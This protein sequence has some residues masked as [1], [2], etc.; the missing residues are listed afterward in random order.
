M[1]KTFS[2]T[3]S[4]LAA[5]A[6]LA[7]APLAARAQSAG[8]FLGIGAGA[9]RVARTNETAARL[10]PSLHLRTGWT[11]NPTVS[12]V[13]EGTLNGIG[14]PNPADP[15]AADS[16][17]NGGAYRNRQLQTGA[18]LLAVQLGSARTLYV[19]PGIGIARHAFTVYRPLPADGYA[20]ETGYEGGP[21][22]GVAVGREIAV[23]P[24]FPLSV[25]A[26]ALYSRGEDSTSPRW[27]AGVQIVRDIRL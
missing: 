7:L 10:G 6:A 15:P 27:T 3:A 24:G 1:R 12:L 4:T 16:A 2:R 22:A 11:F 5:S 18:V 9:S 13:L 19:R 21:A 23:I 25:E 20:A 17:I 8:P 26:M 14:S